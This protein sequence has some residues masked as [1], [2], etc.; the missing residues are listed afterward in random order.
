MGKQQRRYDDANVDED[1]AVAVALIRCDF[2]NIE[3]SMLV[4][5]AVCT[6]NI[7]KNNYR[8]QM[9]RRIILKE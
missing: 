4:L 5:L 8:M 7:L 2:K 1:E 6:I 9:N 3:R